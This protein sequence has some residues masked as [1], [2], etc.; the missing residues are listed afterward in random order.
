MAKYARFTDQNGH[1]VAVNPEQV[2][3][4]RAPVNNRGNV[5]IH[6]DNDHELFVDAAMEEV[7]RELS[8]TY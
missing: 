7:L 1:A 5:V 8:N 3:Y 4:V 2:R 6:F